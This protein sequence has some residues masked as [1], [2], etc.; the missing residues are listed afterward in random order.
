M[1]RFLS[2]S[3]I[4]GS[5]SLSWASHASM[6]VLSSW[7]DFWI[8]NQCCICNC[9]MYPHI[10]Q[11]WGYILFRVLLSG[12]LCWVSN[13]TVSFVIFFVG[14]DVYLCPPNLPM[15]SFGLEFQFGDCVYWLHDKEFQ[16]TYTIGQL[17]W[18]ITAPNPFGGGGL[19]FIR[20]SWSLDRP[21]PFSDGPL[22]LSNAVWQ[23]DISPHSP[24]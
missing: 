16:L 3:A 23:I 24:Y 13:L 11:S 6:I 17:S 5:P 15:N 12:V 4:S 20:A 2:T 21:V 18:V 22:T 9:V 14:I 8:I 19:Y 1:T 10:I 7:V